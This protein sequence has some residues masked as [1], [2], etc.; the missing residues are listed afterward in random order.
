MGE[1]QLKPTPPADQQLTKKLAEL[2][3][4]LEKRVKQLDEE[5]SSLRSFL[6]AVDSLL[7]ER[8][9]RPV[10]ISSPQTQAVK[11]TPRIT[12]SSDTI[13]IMAVNGVRIGSIL[14]RN[15]GLQITPESGL[16]LDANSPPLRAF[17]VGKIFEPMQLKD[18]E[19][20]VSGTIQ[21]EAIL[22]YSIEQEGGKLIAIH[23]QNFG[24][25]RRLLE[26][27]NAIRWTFRRMYEKVTAPKSA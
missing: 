14:I 1:A 27:Q 5:S 13:P 20:A 16:Q 8:S 11:V 4:F 18:K 12:T 15:G 6:E 26:L 25:E 24:D 17:L 19:S 10:E 9:F 7:A 2:K 22:T 3:S 23:V 21:P